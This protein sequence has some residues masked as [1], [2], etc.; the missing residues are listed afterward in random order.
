MDTCLFNPKSQI[1]KS[2]IESFAK[3][4]RYRAFA[5]SSFVLRG[6]DN[7]PSPDIIRRTTPR[8]RNWQTHYFEVVAR[9][10]VQVQI[11]SWAYDPPKGGFFVA[12]LRHLPSPQKFAVRS[13]P[14]REPRRVTKS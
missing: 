6:L 13:L 8:W 14:L 11:L 12:H 4:S 7:P 1:R 2:K 5:P 10:L 9:Q 3:V